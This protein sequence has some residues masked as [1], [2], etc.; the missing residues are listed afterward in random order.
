MTALSFPAVAA[1]QS[2]VVL[3]GVADASVRVVNG[4]NGTAYSIGSGGL[5]ASR[6]GIRTQ[7]DLGYGIAAG[8]W[9]EGTVNYNDGTG[10]SSRFWNR[11]ATVSLLGPL[12]EVRLGHDLTPGYTSF[13]EFDTFGVS[14]LADQGKFYSTAFGSGIEATGLWARAD[15]MISYFTPNSLG[16]FYANLATAF[17]ENVAAKKYNGGRIGYASGPLNVT[18]AYSVFDGL[19]GNLKRSALAASYDFGVARFLA[20]TVRNQYL[21]AARQV[22]QV[23]VVVPISPAASVRANYTRASESGA[24]NGASID[25]NHATQIAMGFTYDFSKR[26]TLYGTLVYLANKGTSAFNFGTSQPPGSRL[27]GGELGVSHRF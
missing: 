14:G 15:N 1:A 2:N 21:S 8:A 24:L 25:P 5:A 17:G 3:F 22:T 19:K 20:S 6:F 16:G 7:E 23:G 18:A 27:R 11:R 9:M 26:T 4:G 12:G 13:G 10:N